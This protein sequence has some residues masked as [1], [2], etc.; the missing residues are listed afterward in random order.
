MGYDQ[1]GR[2]MFCEGS[3]SSTMVIRGGSGYSRYNLLVQDQPKVGRLIIS[4]EDSC[5]S[6]DGEGRS[7]YAQ[8]NAFQP[9][10]FVRAQMGVWKHPSKGDEDNT[11]A[12]L[13]V[14]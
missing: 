6:V 12:L 5:L 2:E 13:E 7:S 10:I 14:L 3:S 9:L 8:E 11:N 4:R 1:L